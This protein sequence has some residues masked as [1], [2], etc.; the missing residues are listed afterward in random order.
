[1]KGQDM[2]MSATLADGERKKKFRALRE[3]LE[4][5]IGT[6]DVIANRT[7]TRLIL[8]HKDGGEV[9]FDFWEDGEL[10]CWEIR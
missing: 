3:A 2:D 7:S 6:E 10:D 1:M 4:S 9:D 5:L 8:Q